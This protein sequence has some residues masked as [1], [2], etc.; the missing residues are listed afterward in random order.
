M[1]SANGCDSISEPQQINVYPLPIIDITNQVIVQ[2]SCGLNNASV[3]SINVTGNSPFTYNWTNGTGTSFAPTLNL[4]NASAGQYYFVATDV[5]GCKDSTA[6]QLTSIPAPQTPLII[7]PS[8]VCEGS[9]AIL[10][11]DNV[12]LS[13]SYTWNFNGSL[14]QSGT[15]L[16]S[17]VITNCSLQNTGNYEI[18]ASNGTCSADTTILLTVNE[19]PLPQISA[20]ELSFCA[21]NSSTLSV[22]NNSN[23]NYQWFLNN[24]LIQGENNS[25]IDISIGGTYQVLVSNNGCDSLS[26]SIVISELPAP[27][28]NTNSVITCLN[29]PTQLSASGSDNYSWQ[30]SQ[31]QFIGNTIPIDSSIAGVFTFTLTGTNINGCT[32]D[33]LIS[34]TINDNPTVLINGIMSDTISICELT[35]T[36]LIASGASTY[37][38]SNLT[39]N[40]TLQVSINQDTTIALIGTDINGCSDTNVVVIEVK[41]LPVF[42]QILGTPTICNGYPTQ[43]YLDT[44]YVNQNYTWVN[45][46]GNVLSTSDSIVITTPGIYQLV[47]GNSC[48]NDTLPI[49]IGQSTIQASF[50]ASDTLN[51][52]PFSVNFNNTS[53][54]ATNYYWLFGN[55]DTATVFSPSTIYNQAGTYSAYLIASNP[56]YCFSSYALQIIVLAE[57][58]Y[59]TVPTVFSPNGDGTNDEF[60]VKQYGL[61]SLNC[62]I[63]NRWGNLIYELE[64]P[65]SKWKPGNEIPE[66]TYYF[67]AEAKG[68]NQKPF[69]AKGYLLLVR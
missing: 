60:F 47:I 46:N 21:G 28:L 9:T 2:A 63:Y 7:A 38:W 22:A 36:N 61:K 6:Y 23:F 42:S 20:T 11:L 62:K 3:S 26:V 24:N 43:L 53:I 16:D 34:V 55:G 35:Q 31:G 65:D 64:N 48:R 44:T 12:D 56:Q 39:T 5:N 57:E 32:S 1:V 50:T 66:G 19:Q 30:S 40:D 59:M 18:I 10:S 45:T 14:I 17:L 37:L 51:V 49:T 58:I 67:I 25:T 33:T 27:I 13:L 29:Q 52:A 41:P 4:T 15:G 54:G 68:L 69:R 8:E